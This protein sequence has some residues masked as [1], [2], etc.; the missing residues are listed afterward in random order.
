MRGTAEF[1][2]RDIVRVRPYE[3]W[4]NNEKFQSCI[5]FEEWRKLSYKKA[6]VAEVIIYNGFYQ[7]RLKFE[8]ITLNAKV[9]FGVFFPEMLIL[10]SEFNLQ[11]LQ[12]FNAFDIRF[13]NFKKPLLS[14]EEKG[15]I[16][17]EMDELLNEYDYH[18]T[19]VGLIKI[20]DTW[21]ENK[22]SLIALFKRHSSY[23]GNYQIVFNKTYKRKIKNHV[24]RSLIKN[25]Q[26]IIYKLIENCDFIKRFNCKDKLEKAKIFLDYLIFE[27]NFSDRITK[28]QAEEINELFSFS[29]YVKEGQKLSKV[30]R[31]V[32]VEAHVDKH[33]MF[34]ELYP[35]LADEL[36][37]ISFTRK[38]VLSIHPID[39][40]TMSFGDSW[41][42]CHTIDK[43]NKRS[44]R[45]NI[46]QGCYS[47]GTES[48]MLDSSS[49]IFYTINESL[50]RNEN[51]KLEL[52]DKSSRC[53]FHLGADKLV[54]G[55]VY[56][57]GKDGAEEVYTEI[58]KTVQE[59]IA[60]C[61]NILDLWKTRFGTE[62]C[63]EM[64]TSKGTH[65]RDYNK[66]S[67]CNVSFF[68]ND[69]DIRNFRKIIVGH[70]PICPC[71]AKEH[72][73]EQTIECYNCYNEIETVI[74]KKCG[75]QIEKKYANFINDSFYCDNCI[76]YCNFHRKIETIDKRFNL[77]VD[78]NGNICNE[79]ARK[80]KILKTPC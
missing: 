66:F 51:K 1:K 34:N 39:Y 35:V 8:D 29:Y 60:Q 11:H 20:V 49:F 17:K 28:E 6:R 74:C 58:R 32:L 79:A 31:K 48:Y 44:Q 14:C 12:P 64:I 38:I 65:Y 41:T 75:Q 2:V 18:P 43:N 77:P 40:Y 33:E 70:N 21:F 78:C 15:K 68:R 10:D 7:Y 71:C 36:S 62:I 69:A 63:S 37:P 26:I 16:I 46:Y 4:A 47:S 25:F 5:L 13:A 73:E 27:E 54:Q 42:S 45:N 24:V 52:S 61:F 30:I 80:I 9:G 22:K 53:M 67:D 59:T 76:F 72:T 57:Q 56:P 23:N 3:E 19:T 55:R 50:K